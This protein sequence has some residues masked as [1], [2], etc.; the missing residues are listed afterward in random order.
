MPEMGSGSDLL[1]PGAFSAKSPI[2]RV[3][4]SGEFAGSIAVTRHWRPG[5]S[6]RSARFTVAESIS[7]ERHVTQCRGLGLKSALRV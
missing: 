7:A 4:N 3:G 2:F 5:N 1:R 6:Q